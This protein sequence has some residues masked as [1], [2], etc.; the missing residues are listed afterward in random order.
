MTLKVAED[1]NFFKNYFSKYTNLTISY[2]GKDTN[3]SGLAQFTT[4]GKGCL[5]ICCDTN[6]IQIVLFIIYYFD[7]IS[8]DSYLVV[9]TIIFRNIKI[10]NNVK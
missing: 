5:I 9:V 7:T 2:L 8:I 4:K 6:N 10:N 3:G 1:T